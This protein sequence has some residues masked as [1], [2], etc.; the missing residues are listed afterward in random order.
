[1]GGALFCCYASGHGPAATTI[2]EFAAEGFTHIVCH[3]LAS[4]DEAEA[5][6]W[7]PR[8]S[9]GI[10]IAQFSARLRR[11]ECA[12]DWVGHAVAIG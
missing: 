5:I 12:V 6:S 4:H 9:L 7:R 3:C 2:E 10:T 8:I 11:A 1:L